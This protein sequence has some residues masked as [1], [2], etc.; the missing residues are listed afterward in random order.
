M[1][2]TQLGVRLAT[3]APLYLRPASEVARR[4]LPVIS[5]ALATNRAC[6]QHQKV[7]NVLNTCSVS[8]WIER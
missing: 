5:S 6:P 7:G 3:S 1:A 8:A 2:L 4:L